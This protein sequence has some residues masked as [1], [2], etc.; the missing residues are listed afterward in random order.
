MASIA[1]THY[2]IT[3]NDYAITCRVVDHVDNQGEPC[4]YCDDMSAVV[5]HTVY[6]TSRAMAD[7][8]SADCCADCAERLII[9]Y[10]DA[11]HDVTV[12]YVDTMTLLDAMYADDEFVAWAD[13]TAAYSI[14][15]AHP[16]DD[17]SHFDAW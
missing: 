14:R 5:T 6:G 13:S 12:E 10:C 8:Y 16:G 3:V 15:M 2:G 7:D 4:P 1:T 9:D 17:R 11:S